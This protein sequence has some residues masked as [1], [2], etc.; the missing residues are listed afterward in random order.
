MKKIML[1]LTVSAFA[2]KIWSQAG[3]INTYAGN[4]TPTYGGDGG[5]ATAGQLYYPDQLSWDAGGD[6]IIGDNN[7]NVIRKITPAGIISTVAGNGIQETQ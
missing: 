1:I 3:N 2:G 5:Q 7:N 4:G 6:L